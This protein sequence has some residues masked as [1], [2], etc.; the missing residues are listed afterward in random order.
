MSGARPCGAGVKRRADAGY[1]VPRQQ[2][3]PV[4]RLERE[5]GQVVQSRLGQ[6]RKRA[7]V[8]LGVAAGQR[9]GLVV[10]VDQQRLVK[11]RLDEA[12]RMT[13]VEAGQF[14]A[15]EESLDVL[16]HC[17]S[18]E[19]G[20][21]A[22]LR[23]RY[24]GGV[25]DREDVRRGLGLK[26][27]A[28]GRHEPERIAQALR[29]GDVLGA[30]VHGD[31]DQQVVGDLALVPAVQPPCSGVDAACREF[32]LD[33]D[34]ALGQQRARCAEATGFVKAPSSGVTNVSSTSSRRPRCAQLP[35][36]EEAEL[37]RGHRALDRHVDHV[38]HETAPVEAIQGAPQGGCALKRVEGVDRATPL[39]SLQALG[40]LRRKRRAGGDHQ[41]VVLDILAVNE[42]DGVLGEID[43]L[44]LGETEVDA[45]AKLGVA[46]PDDL[47]GLREPEWN[48]QQAGLVDV[49]VVAVDD[50][51]LCPSPKRRASR[52]ASSVPPVPPPR[53]RILCVIASPILAAAAQCLKGAMPLSCCGILRSREDASRPRD[54]GL[55]ASET[56]AIHTAGISMGSP[57]VIQSCMPPTVV[58]DRL[59]RIAVY[60]ERADRG[61]CGGALRAVQKKIVVRL[62]SS[63]RSYCSI[64]SWGTLLAV[65]GCSPV[66]MRQPRVHQR[67]AAIDVVDHLGAQPRSSTPGASSIS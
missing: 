37:Q 40:L 2:H 57:S 17:L 19:V 7:E 11:A 18:L 47:A 10:E 33:P 13:V 60:E 8:R 9:L 27:V 54:R 51:D 64:C 65:G 61:G 31:R 46:R 15:C 14:V 24:V 23:G 49:A 44:D 21:R 41:H 55:F 6:Q 58:E 34:A 3:V 26:C 30:A 45:A 56:V 42:M 48:E 16:R 53:M 66:E 35:V 59:G 36:G 43:V 62:G 4:E 29:A 28:I 1:V 25:A 52:L 38:D 5:L 20:D 12:V 39:G 63:G 32:G 50:R 67:Q 22:R